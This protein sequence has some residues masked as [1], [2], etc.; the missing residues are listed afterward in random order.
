MGPFGER[1]NGAADRV[2]TL[3]ECAYDP[4][5]DEAVRPG[6]EDFGLGRNCRHRDCSEKFVSA[7]GEEFIYVI[8]E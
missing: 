5:G 3:K 8:A 7:S 6:N 1:A 4:D 2:A